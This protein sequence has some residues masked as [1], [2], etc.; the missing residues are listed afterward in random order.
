MHSTQLSWRI[1]WILATVIPIGFLGTFFAWPVVA[2]AARGLTT[3]AFVEVLGAPRTWRIVWQTVWMALAGTLGSLVAGIPGAYVLYRLTFP[4]RALARV[5]ATVPFV[6]PTVVVG[7]AFHAAFASREDLAS[8][9]TA[10]VIAMVFFNFS[11]VVRTVGTLWEKL[12]PQ[13]EAAAATLGASPLRVFLTVT[14]PQLAPAVAASAGLVFLFCSTAYGIVLTLG[15]PG[16]GTVET[17]MWVQ[18]VTFL[19]LDRAAVFSLIQCVIVTAAVV[20]SV[21]LSARYERH[22]TGQDTYSH[23]ISRH[24]IPVVVAVAV[25]TVVVIVLPLATIVV[26]SLAGGGRAY[27]LLSTSGAG[28][29]GGITAWEALGNSLVTALV[30]A[31]IA[32][33]VGVG[34]ALVVSRTPTTR[35]AT[36][37]VRGVDILALTPLG[38]SAVTVGFGFFITLVGVV[39]RP[40]LVPLAQAVV[41]L[42]LVTRALVPVLRAIEPGQREAAATLGASPWRVLATIDLAGARR[43]LGVALGFALAMSI[44]EFGATSFLASAQYVTL[45]VLI[46]RLLGRPGADNYEMA[47]AASVILGIVTA[48]LMVGAAA[49]GAQAKNT[50]RKVEV[51]R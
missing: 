19:N 24:D 27:R 41:A 14:A 50:R 15:K 11:V 33:V 34:I 20:V 30:A 51:A 8:S 42:P 37:V 12:S 48:V 25:F 22:L 9:T 13:Q 35:I 39:E 1:F 29:A 10:V 38:V 2:M 6:L 28:Y 49:L 36:V 40:V 46:V 43:G 3:S 26:K 31:V 32:L 23:P 5:V 4:G 16:Y 21:R 7:V 45:P 18:T 44:G 17:E 47:L